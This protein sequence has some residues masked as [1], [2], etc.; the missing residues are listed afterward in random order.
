MTTD[1]KINVGILAV[2]LI[3]MALVV[4][5]RLQEHKDAMFGAAVRQPFSMPQSESETRTDQCIAERGYALEDQC[6]RE[7]MT[8]MMKGE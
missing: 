2:F 4:P 7:E 5:A 6:V 1:D 8:R 3:F